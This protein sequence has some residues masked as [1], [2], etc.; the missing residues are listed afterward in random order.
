MSTRYSS[1]V[2][3]ICDDSAQS[4]SLPSSTDLIELYTVEIPQ[5]KAIQCVT[6]LVV[7]QLWV[8]EGYYS[9]AYG[10]EYYTTGVIPGLRTIS[11]PDNSSTKLG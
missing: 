3:N 6:P 10:E 9:T 1:Y 7:R 4:S 8:E 5:G 2:R 11:L